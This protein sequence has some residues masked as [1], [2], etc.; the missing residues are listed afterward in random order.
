MPHLRCRFVK[1]WPEQYTCG[2]ACARALARNE[3]V[4]AMLVGVTEPP[5]CRWCN[6]YIEFLDSPWQIYARFRARQS[7]HYRAGA[8]R[9]L[10]RSRLSHSGIAFEVFDSNANTAFRTQFDVGD[11][12][13]A[14]LRMVE[15]LYVFGAS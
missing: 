5:R 7:H 3:A 10:D 6:S 2:T 9:D 11:A 4:A 8:R 15:Q 12:L 1:V 13:D 14:A